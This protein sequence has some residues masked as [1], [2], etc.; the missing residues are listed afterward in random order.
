M[1]T[2]ASENMFEKQGSDTG[3]VNSFVTRDENH[4]LH[5]P[6]VNHDQNRVKTGGEWQIR[7]HITQDLLEW[8]GGGE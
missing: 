8:M 7:D 3:G 5:K 1:E 6:M 2:K 4:P